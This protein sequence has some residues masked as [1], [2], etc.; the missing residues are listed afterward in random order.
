MDLLSLFYFSELAKDLNMT[1]TA[2]RLFVSQQTL[3]NHIK[4][5]EEYYACKLLYRKPTLSL[6]CAGEYVLKFAKLVNKENLNLQDILSDI[7]QQERGIILFGASS[8]RLNACLPNILPAFVVA[9]PHVE[10]RLTDTIS[11]QLEPMVLNGQLDLAIVMSRESNPKLEDYKLMDDQIYL[12]VSDALM[13]THYGSEATALKQRAIT[14]ANVKD[15]ARLPFCLLSNRMGRE[16][17]TCFDEAGVTPIPFLTSTYTQVST[18]TC[19]QGLAAGFISQMSLVNQRGQ[20]PGDINIFPL[21]RRN[22]PVTQRLSLIRHKDRYL[23]HYAKHFLDLLFQY[24]A[25]TQQVQM[26]RMV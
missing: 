15:F 20:I 17:Q 25:D 18:T 9:Y 14:G 26:E 11:S 10:I 12:C 13:Q 21:H 7:E 19:F 22:A 3:S 2:S 1:H 8:L 4:R 6:T 24:F 5:L 16:V 23:S